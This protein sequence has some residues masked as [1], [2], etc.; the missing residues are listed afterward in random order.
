MENKN[1]QASLKCRKKNYDMITIP[2]PKG[3]R[4]KLITLAN[5]NGMTMN[6]Y[7]RALIER[8]LADSPDLLLDCEATAFHS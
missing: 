6:A 5:A 4:D 8:A 2:L 7:V 1:S 3:Q